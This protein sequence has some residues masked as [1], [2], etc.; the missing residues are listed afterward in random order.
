MA[1]VSP[2]LQEVRLQADLAM[3]SKELN[4]PIL[5]EQTYGI[6]SSGIAGAPLCSDLNLNNQKAATSQDVKVPY[7]SR[8]AQG[9]ATVRGFNPAFEGTMA[10]QTIALNG[11]R[12]EIKISDLMHYENEVDRSTQIQIAI[13]QKIRNLRE[14]LEASLAVSLEAARTQVSTFTTNGELVWDG[15][16][17]QMDSALAFKDDMYSNLKEMSMENDLGQSLKFVGSAGS[18]R[19][20]EYLSAQ[21]DSNNTN[22]SYNKDILNDIVYSSALVAGAGNKY[23]GYT[24]RDGAFGVYFWNNKLH[25]NGREAGGQYWGTMRDELFGYDIELYIERGRAD[26]S[27][28]VTGAE[29]DYNESL[30][31]YV[32]FGFLAAPNNNTDIYKIV[33]SA[34]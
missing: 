31:M 23:T 15:V 27:G 32:D 16:G 7:Y 9:A 1:F 17:F 12:E 26:N 29:M 8:I 2:L 4:R 24:F 25:T 14:R 19:Q 22:R 33:Q 10:Y 34:T 3:I 21:G 18:M 13:A 5:K 20:F 28:V 6:L 30:V 11:L